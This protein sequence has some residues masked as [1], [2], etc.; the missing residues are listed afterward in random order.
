MK[1]QSILYIIFLAVIWTASLG[2]R[3]PAARRATLLLAS[4]VFYLTLGPAF[5]VVLIAS[6]LFNY[7]WG[8]VLRRKTNSSTLWVGLLI[9][10]ALL[11][12]FKHLGVAL[13]FLHLQ[14]SFLTSFIAPVGLSF[15]TFQGMSYLLD[16]YREA[17]DTSPTLLE[18]LLYMAFWPT[19][20]AGPICR[21]GEMV[22][23]FRRMKDPDLEDVSAGIQ[24]LL[25]GIF[26]KVVLAELLAHGIEASEGVT[27][28]F[29]TLS[30]GWSGVDVWFL[31]VG[32]GFQLFFD[33]A[34][35]SNIAIGSARLFGIKLRENFDDPYLSR[36]P[37]EFWT[38]WHMSLSSW[39]RDYV[40]FPLATARREVWWRNLALVLSMVIFGLW[41]GLTATFALWGLYNGL[42]L[43]GHRLWQQA[44]PRR[45]PGAD[46]G[47]S[48]FRSAGAVLSWG[49]TFALISLGWILFRANSLSQ[50]LAMLRAVVDPHRYF[51][52]SMRLNFYALVFAVAAGYFIFVGLRELVRRAQQQPVFARVIFATS[53]VLY[54]VLIVAILIWSRFATTFVYVQF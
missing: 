36:T 33:F 18:F 35:Y 37:S 12:S 9:N 1:F 39:I 47:F 40:F 14:S 52:L 51:Q 28:G 32:F 16:I 13:G 34:G 20:L 6:S 31:A 15:Y 38:R 3:R 7:G 25:F 44:R 26:M 21:V 5:V 4:Y 27:T 45:I 19:V 53:P 17:E 43:V 46:P 8:V 23:Q 50:S 29:D 49:V 11:M 10:I 48:I 22:P 2:L 24:R 54:A 42:L 30:G 41:H